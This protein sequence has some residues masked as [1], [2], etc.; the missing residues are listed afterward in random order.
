MTSGVPVILIA[1]AS[2]YERH[3]VE[4]ALQKTGRRVCS[5]A[6]TAEAERVCAEN[7]GA[8]ILVI[9]FGLLEAPRNAQWR[10]LRRRHPDLGAVVCCPISQYEIQRTDCNTLRVHPSNGAGICDALDLLDSY[11]LGK[12]PAAWTKH[13]SVRAAT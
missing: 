1:S 8:S 2:S 9:D 6:D 13:V 11:R 7:G 4:R 10:K 3:C 12:A 5:V